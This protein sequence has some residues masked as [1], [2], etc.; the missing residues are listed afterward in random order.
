LSLNLSSEKK[1]GFLFVALGIL[2]SLLAAGMIY[3]G[4]SKMFPSVP[5][6]EVVQPIVAGDPL[7]PG[8]FK[9]VKKPEAGL[10]QGVIRP[11][12][13]FSGFIA[14][15][16][17]APGDILRISNVIILENINL[18]ILSAR[19]AYLD[20]FELR[21]VEV[22]IESIIGMLPGMKAGD[23]V[24]IISVYKNEAPD[25]P[26]RA[27]Q[28]LIAETIIEGVPVIGV[29]PREEGQG[30]LIVALTKDQAE[31]YALHREKGR[32]SVSLRPFGYKDIA[33]KINNAEVNINVTN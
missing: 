18:P 7:S 30:A 10:P 32:I 31:V 16:G 6:L 5:V 3:S 11:G 24:D 29:R 4:A 8:M 17:M 23:Y 22:P 14:A 26:G 12:V 28:S 15:N 27:S 1:S 25:S 33:E 21:G 19:L 13:D 20:N 9:E 2:C